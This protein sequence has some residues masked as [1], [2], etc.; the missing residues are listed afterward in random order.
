MGS[1]DRG[2]VYA[3][4]PGGLLNQPSELTEGLIQNHATRHEHARLER[5]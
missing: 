1:A 2:L 5:A 3:E 4:V